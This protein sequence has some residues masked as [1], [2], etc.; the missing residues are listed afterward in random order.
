[1]SGSNIKEMINYQIYGTYTSLTT[2]GERKRKSCDDFANIRARLAK[3]KLATTNT[4]EGMDL[5]E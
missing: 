5:I 1:M 2:D 3:V 4:Y